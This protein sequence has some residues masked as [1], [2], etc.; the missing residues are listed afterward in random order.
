MKRNFREM[1]I[2]YLISGHFVDSETPEQ[3]HS[4]KPEQHTQT[5]DTGYY[6]TCDTQEVSKDDSTIKTL[7]R[8]A[9]TSPRIPCRESVH[10]QSLAYLVRSAAE[11]SPGR[12]WPLTQRLAFFISLH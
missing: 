10:G 9:L 1:V 3:P 12:K 2:C 6:R 7:A 4:L 11:N 8:P 5:V